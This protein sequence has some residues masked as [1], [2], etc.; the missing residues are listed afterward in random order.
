MEDVF[1]YD[2][3]RPLLAEM[4]QSKIFREK[5]KNEI[6]KILGVRLFYKKN[7]EGYFVM[8][9]LGAV[10][11]K[12]YYDEDSFSGISFQ[13]LIESKAIIV[14]NQEELQGLFDNELGAG[15]SFADMARESLLIINDKVK[16]IPESRR[17]ID[18]ILANHR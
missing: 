9:F 14:P 11:N 2:S 6:G 3:T 7:T 10:P 4:I 15:S 17:T 13:P 18:A 1:N 16:R 12:L 8:G 5:A